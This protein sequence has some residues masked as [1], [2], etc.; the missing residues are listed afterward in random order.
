MGGMTVRN[1]EIL[2]ELRSI[3]VDPADIPRVAAHDELPFAFPRRLT[4]IDTV[5]PGFQ[6]VVIV[7]E[8]FLNKE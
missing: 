6:D 7:L 8:L 1:L 2:F 3:K 5:D 4:R